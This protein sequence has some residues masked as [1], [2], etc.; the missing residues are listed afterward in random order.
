[1]GCKVV[2]LQDGRKVLAN[3]RPG[4]KLTARDMQTLEEYAEF[5]RERAAK[6]KGKR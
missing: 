5:C 2:R 1:M 3:V 6:K 4:V